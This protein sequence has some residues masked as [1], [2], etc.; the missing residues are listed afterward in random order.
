MGYMKLNSRRALEAASKI[1]HSHIIND[2]DVAYFLNNCEDIPREVSEN[3]FAEKSV[4]IELEEPERNP[5]KHII[6]VDGGYNEI[7]VNKRFPAS[8]LAYFQFGALFFGLEHLEKLEKQSFLFPED[9]QKFK[10]LERI[11]LIIPTRHISYK[12]NTLLNSIRQ[13]IFEFFQQERSGESLIDTLQWFLFFEY[14]P[15]GRREVYRL[16]SCPNPECPETNIPIK[17]RELNNH[18]CRCQACGT[19]IYLTDAFRLHEAIDEEFGAG[20]ILGYLTTLIEQMI[21]VHNIKYILKKKPKLL[22]EILF[23]KDGPLGF[24]GQTANMHK[25]MRKLCNYL[26]ENH[27]L[28]LAGLE[29]SGAFVDHA[30]IICSHLVNGGEPILKPGEVL[31]LSNEYIYTYVMPGIPD[32]TKPYARTSYYGSKLIYHTKEGSVYVATLPVKDEK[33]VLKPQKRDFK[34]I[35]VILT[36]IAKLRC[37]M[38]ENSLVPIALVNQLVSIANRPSSVLLEK[39]SRGEVGG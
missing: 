27:T 17:K 10:E 9:M 8:R 16:A 21:L 33:V 1:N 31:L 32:E 14:D 35:D 2:P 36:N 18:T 22:E 12:C 39:F 20:G 4:V 3:D 15:S 28:Y 34:N 5:I 24:F 26:L 19:D 25:P 7:E 37:D 30:D 23:I 6:A 11:K 38:Y 29:K 13:A